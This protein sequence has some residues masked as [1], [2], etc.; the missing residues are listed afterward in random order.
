MVGVHVN[1][2]ATHIAAS[3]AIIEIFLTSRH[4]ILITFPLDWQGV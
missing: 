1:D 3:A 2:A 4:R